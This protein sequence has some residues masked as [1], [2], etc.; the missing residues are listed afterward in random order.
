MGLLLKMVYVGQT[1][2]IKEL[3]PSVPPGTR[4]AAYQGLQGASYSN[5]A[6]YDGSVHPAVDSSR[7]HRTQ[8]RSLPT[9][10]PSMIL[11]SRNSSQSPGMQQSEIHSAKRNG[12]L[13]S[14][15]NFLLTAF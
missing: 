13:K 14:F 10:Q 4:A 2:S 11:K 15:A 5:N 1:R 8:S 3:G 7:N 6:D 9:A 12:H